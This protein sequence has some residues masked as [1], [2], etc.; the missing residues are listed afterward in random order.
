L[1]EES[2]GVGF[3][4][5]FSG[6]VGV[7]LGMAGLVLLCLGYGGCAARQAARESQAWQEELER[8]RSKALASSQPA[9][10]RDAA[11]PSPQEERRLEAA[12]K[13]RG[14]TKAAYDR[15]HRGLTYSEVVEIIGEE[16]E[17]LARPTVMGV[18][19]CV[20]YQWKTATGQTMKGY[21]QYGKLFQ[22]DQLD[23]E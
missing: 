1:I 13:S 8:A 17:E 9:A 12:S 16:G 18:E 20:I 21:F 4:K 3:A 23:P 10:M 6:A 22:V 14:V 2:S 7:G 11:R 15:I 19:I 5:V